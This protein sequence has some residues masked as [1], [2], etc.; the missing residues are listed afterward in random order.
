M[1]S[2]VQNTNV[3]IRKKKNTCFT[4][5]VHKLEPMPDWFLPSIC[6]LFIFWGRAIYC[7]LDRTGNCCDVRVQYSFT[8]TILSSHLA[9]KL[10][11]T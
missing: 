9:L 7:L 10:I 5:P 3:Q 8:I 11:R 4:S 1:Y 6:L 2:Y